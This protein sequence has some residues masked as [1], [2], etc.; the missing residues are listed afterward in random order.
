MNP[1]DQCTGTTLAKV[2]CENSSNCRIKH[3]YRIPQPRST[4]QINAAAAALAEAPME[5]EFISTNDTT[6]LV[7][8]AVKD[9]F[10]S[11]WPDIKFSVRSDKYAGGSSVDVRWIDGP[12]RREVE[13]VIKQF[14]GS[15]FDTMQDMKLSRQTLV[16]ME[17]GSIRQVHYGPD[18][19]FAH[20]SVS[21]ELLTELEPHIQQNGFT[22]GN[23]Q[24]DVCMKLMP[25]GN[26]YTADVSSGGSER[27]VFCCSKRCGA[28]RAAEDPKMLEKVRS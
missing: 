28:R 23:E 21:E 11:E 4:A 19:V 2:R 13:A 15:T 20:R 16:A 26:C 10:K 14:E 17:D 6:K 18:H 22:R 12:P 1:N 25:E 9:T 3:K 24:C 5:T 27:I 7:R 8:Q